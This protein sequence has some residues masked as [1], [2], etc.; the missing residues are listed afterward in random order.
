MPG[1]KCPANESRAG[2]L[3][4]YR[5]WKEELEV[6]KVESVKRTVNLR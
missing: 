5:L 2:I 3:E 1:Q 4:N 6:V